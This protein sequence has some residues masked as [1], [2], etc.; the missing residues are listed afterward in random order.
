MFK[1]HFSKKRIRNIFNILEIVKERIL[2]SFFV[3]FMNLFLKTKYPIKDNNL[4]EKTNVSSEVTGN[5][6]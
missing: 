3:V 6:K 4:K 1:F 2:L 5:F